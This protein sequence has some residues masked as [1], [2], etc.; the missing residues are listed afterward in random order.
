M[1][2]RQGLRIH[3]GE[4]EHTLAEELANAVTHGIGT[5]LAAAAFVLL[6]VLGTVHG[7]L[8]HVLALAVYG[9]TLVILYLAS[10]LYHS[11][12]H[13]RARRL[14]RLFD[15]AAIFLLIA[16]TYTPYALIGMGGAAGW[17]LFAAIWTAAAAGI[18]FKV[19]CLDRYERASLVF[20]LAMG[21]IGVLALGPLMR[22]IETEGLLLLALG[23]LAYTGGVLFYLW[24]GL[25]FNHA[26]WHLFVL[27]GS[28]SHFLS[29]YLYVAAP[30]AA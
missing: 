23:G 29:I 1:R 2:T 25:P 11:V 4:Q 20:Y 26:V 17:L 15:H 12:R 5:L 27:C 8:E 13:R 18:A 10:T 30:N 22:S 28:A 3:P 9:A 6:V 19:M 16:G 21:W 14:F 24:E 7:T